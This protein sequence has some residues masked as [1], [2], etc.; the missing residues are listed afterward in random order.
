MIKTI[1]FDNG[2]VLVEDDWLDFITQMTKRYPQKAE[3][4]LESERQATRGNMKLEDFDIVLK[5]QTMG[6]E[7]AFDP[8]SPNMIYKDVVDYVKELSKQYKVCLLTNEFST[9]EIFNKEWHFDQVFGENVFTSSKIGFAKPD[10]E[11]F[12]F[13]LA[14]L[15]E[16]PDEILFIDDRGVNTDSAR[17]LGMNVIQFK[18]LEILKID[19]PKKIEVINAQK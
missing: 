1:I 10:T 4:I 12:R 15:G 7:L 13:V 8:Y 5:K 3:I 19:L 17:S 14:E 2:G 18:S 16:K 6:T 11:I 9:Y